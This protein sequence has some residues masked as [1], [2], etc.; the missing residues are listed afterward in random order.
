MDEREEERRQVGS[1]AK[2]SYN[3]CSRH[4]A[5]VK[6]GPYLNK[7]AYI[8]NYILY[9]LAILLVIYDMVILYRQPD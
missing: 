5:R 2:V 7:L 8:Y 4:F 1:H 6:G 9:M 3:T